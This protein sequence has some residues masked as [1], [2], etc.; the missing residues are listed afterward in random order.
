MSKLQRLRDNIAA[1]S[2]F[3]V[4]FIVIMQFSFIVVLRN[5]CFQFFGI[6]Y[7]PSTSSRRT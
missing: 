6:Q 1:I 2:H 4:L 7:S 5:H 3:P